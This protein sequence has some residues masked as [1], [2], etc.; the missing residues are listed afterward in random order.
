MFADDITQI[1]TY[2][3]KSEQI[4][5]QHTARAIENINNYEKQWKIKTN[6]NKFKIIPIAKNKTEPVIANGDLYPYA[7]EGQLLG[8]KITKTGYKSFIQEKTRKAQATLTKLY[9]FRRL[10]TK[11]K[12]KLY[13]VLIKPIL[14]Y[15]PVPIHALSKT[16]IK[17]MQIIQNKALRF[18]YGIRYPD[19][20][21]NEE[22]HQRAEIEPLNVILYD[23]AT[24]IWN[25][26]ED[27][28]T[29]TGRNIIETNQR[30]NNNTRNHRWFRSSIKAIQQPRPP[31]TF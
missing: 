6:I 21:T 10:S 4:M 7:T 12:K 29:E 14:E 20:V 22:L 27:L 28:N 24:K 9:R 2:P 8:L 19:I 31:P 11:N 13:M 3:W 5:A 26:I 1:I 25:Q 23:R 15:P 17:Q 16:N 18:I 30:I